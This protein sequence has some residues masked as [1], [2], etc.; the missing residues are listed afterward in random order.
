MIPAS[1]ALALTEK[2]AA[3]I[4]F[5]RSVE[6]LSGDYSPEA[7]VYRSA[8]YGKQSTWVMGC[9]EAEFEALKTK[10]LG[11]GYRITQESRTML[12]G[13]QT[14]PRHNV[15]FLLEW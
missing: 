14:L 2:A 1:E 11:L 5:L 9:P 3:A 15:A 10:L 6:D 4:A 7:R 12:L 8:V 13:G